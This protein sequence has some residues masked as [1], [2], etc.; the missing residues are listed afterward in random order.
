MDDTIK[1]SEYLENMTKV[2]FLGAIPD[3]NA[4]S[5]WMRRSDKDL[6]VHLRPKDPVSESYR[7]IRTNLLFMKGNDGKG[8]KNI[9]VTSPGPQEGKTTT[10]CNLAISMAQNGNKVLI[11]DADMRRPRV[12]A[13]FRVKNENGLSEYLSGQIDMETAVKNTKI[14]NL[15][16]VNGGHVP[17]NPSELLHGDK[18]KEFLEKAHR[19]YDIVIFDS[20]P[21]VVVTD[22]KVLSEVTDGIIIVLRSGKTSKRVFP[23]IVQSLDNAKG[24]II[25]TVLNKVLVNRANPYYHYYSRYYGR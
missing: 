20:P 21:L 4:A 25:G 13:V 5:R 19:S 1:D 24:K 14:E 17:P 7:L 2:P 9:V 12:H 15:F 23:K 8:L 18:M 22:A 10:L 16:L 3:I 11:V 6:I